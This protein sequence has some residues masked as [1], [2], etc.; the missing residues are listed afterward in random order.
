MHYGFTE[1]R[2]ATLRFRGPFQE[3]KDERDR[4]RLPI[5]IIVHVYV[6]IPPRFGFQ[7]TRVVVVPFSLICA[8]DHPHVLKIL[9]LLVEAGTSCTRN[10]GRRQR[11]RYRAAAVGED[12]HEQQQQRQPSEA[13]QAEAR[14]SR[15]ADPDEGQPPLSLH[16]HVHDDLRWSGKS[17]SCGGREDVAAATGRATVR[18]P[19]HKITISERL[20][21]ASPVESTNMLRQSE[22]GREKLATTF[23]MDT[24]S[25]RQRRRLFV[26]RSSV[27]KSNVIVF[28]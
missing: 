19:A 18:R 2:E 20:T 8:R 7:S 21:C 25:V 16:S 23:S 14:P 5:V 13:C 1:E 17:R 4:Y 12:R 9:P 3:T 26:D 11:I 15:P 10:V 24:Y 22:L 6:S 28:S 27:L